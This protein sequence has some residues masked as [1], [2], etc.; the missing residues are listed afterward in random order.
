MGGKS[1]LI[2]TG[3]ADGLVA[4]LVSRIGGNS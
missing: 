4:F 3:D 2:G 1:T